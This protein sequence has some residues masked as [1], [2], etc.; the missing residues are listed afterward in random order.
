MS[1]RNPMNERYSSDAEKPAGKTR[2]SAASAKP[3]SKAAS[4]VHIEEKK[5]SGK[6]KSSSA[7]ASQKQKERAARRE[8]LNPDTPEYK[9]LH[10]V[11]VVMIVIAI[12]LTAIGLIIGNVLDNHSMGMAMV[13]VGDI[14]LVIGILLDIFKLSKMRA[15]YAEEKTKDKS[16]A[17]TAKKKAEAK[18]IAEE[19]KNDKRTQEYRAAQKVKAEEAEQKSAKKKSKN[20][21]SVKNV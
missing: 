16:K 2:K 1:T 12:A 6:Q 4:S 10:A 20:P 9:K 3:V 21:F 14:F 17:A 19:D 8:Y 5:S 18:E 11:W 7:R 15:R 13:I